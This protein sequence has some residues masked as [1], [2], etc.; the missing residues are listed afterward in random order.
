M[1]LRESS[2]ELTHLDGKTVNKL[3]L[4]LPG[5]QEN[6]ELRAM[7]P[8]K[9]ASQLGGSHFLP[10]TPARAQSQPHRALVSAEGW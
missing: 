9:P 2:I 3:R 7:P 6:P 10:A 4:L 8:P 5:G 1:K